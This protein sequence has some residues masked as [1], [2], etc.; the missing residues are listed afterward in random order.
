VT[1]GRELNPYERLV[2]SVVDYAV[3]MLDANGRVMSWNPGAERLKGYSAD[4]ILGEPYER[5]FTPEDRASGLPGRILAQA[6]RDGRYDTEGWRIRKDGTTFWAL[7]VLDAIHDE[8][9]ALIGYAKVTRDITE[10]RAAEQKLAESERRFR[11]LVEGVTDYAIFMLDPFGIVTNWNAGAQRIKGYQADEVVGR[12]FSMFYTPEDA[13]AGLPARALQAAEREG[14]YEAEGWRVRKDGTRFWAS[15]VIDAIREDGRL[16][17]FAKVTRD[18]TDKRDAAQRLEETRNQLFQAQKMEALGQLTGGLAHDFNNLLTAITSGAE[19]GLRRIDDADAVRRYLEGVRAAAERGRNLTRQLLAFARRQPLEMQAVD[20]HEQLPVTADLLR[21]SLRADIRLSLDLPDDLWPVEADP[22][23]L[24]LAVLNLGFN[25]RDAIPKSGAVRIS[26]RNVVLAGAPEGL[27]GEYVAIEVAD[28]GPGIA[29]E[30]RDRIFEPFFTTKGFGEGT[31]LGLSQVYGFARQAEGTIT[32]ASEPGQGAT[33]TLYLRAARGGER[34]RAQIGASFTPRVLVVED[35]PVVAE[36]A[37]D[38]IAE[39]GY[40]T[41]VVASSAEALDALSRRGP[42][43]L[44]FSDVIMPGGLSGLELARRI[45]ARHPELPVLLTTGYSERMGNSE[46]PLVVKP[47]S[48]AEL[49]DHLTRLI[50]QPA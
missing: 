9:G 1:K 44:V 28:T 12:H 33:F 5:F 29:P 41:H 34:A 39:L 10:R 49:R 24:E 16:V 21:H 45:R 23:Q 8:T 11:L 35:D 6:A 18:I 30:I 40:K 7:A 15:V 47:Y 2:L 25:A 48:L 19:L 43:D 36:L 20:L 22:G 3:F 46:F 38:L 31:G 4:E 14:R 42:F 32:L 37:E 17:G 26:A 50:E 13:D 27:T